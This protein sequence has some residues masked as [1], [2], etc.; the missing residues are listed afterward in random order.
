M[1]KI[2]AIGFDWGGVILQQ[3]DRS[4]SN[5]ASEFLGVE[6]ESFRRAYFLHNHLI[7]K[8][9]NSRAFDQAT[10]MWSK[11]LSELGL[12]D[13]LD[14]FMKFVQSRPKGEVSQSMVELL[15]RLKNRGWKLGLLSNASAE[16]AQRIR[17]QEC[18][19]LFEVTLFSA[20]IGL[21]KPEPEAFLKFSAELDVPITELVFIDDSEHSLST[22]G[23]VGYMPIRFQ[24]TKTLI[25]QLQTLGI[26]I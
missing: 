11:I 5:V 19:K 2:G 18:L 23:E 20:E 4:F 13:R 9:A 17:T 7:N 15:E 8:G 24:N 10:E 3:I 22:A 6:N 21:M 12:V 1:K 14:L 16:G 26:E 25:V